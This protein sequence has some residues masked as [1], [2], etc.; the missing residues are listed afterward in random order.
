MVVQ[1]SPLRK[2]RDRLD[3]F[4]DEHPILGFV[5]F[6]IEITVILLSMLAAGVAIIFAWVLVVFVGWGLWTL[7][8]KVIG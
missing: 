6:P 2:F 8:D 3:D 1:Q 4:F 5:A 7:L